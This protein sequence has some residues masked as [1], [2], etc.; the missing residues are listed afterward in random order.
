VGYGVTLEIIEYANDKVFEKKFFD[1]FD[2]LMVKH[3]GKIVH[4]IVENA[5]KIKV[6]VIKDVFDE[7]NSK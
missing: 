1:D 4:N 7:V 2:A 5:G 3:D 6:E